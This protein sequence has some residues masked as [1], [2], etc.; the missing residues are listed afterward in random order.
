[1]D[2]SATEAAQCL[3]DTINNAFLFPLIALLSAV[4]FVVFLYGAFEYVRNSASQEGRQT[5]QRHLLYGVIGLLVMFSA[6][7]LLQIAAGTFGLSAENRTVMCGEGTGSIGPGTAE[8]SSG[9]GS[10][11]TETSID[12]AP[13]INPQPGDAPGRPAPPSGP[14][15]GGQNGLPTVDTS[16]PSTV[17][18]TYNTLDNPTNCGADRVCIEDTWESDCISRPGT[19][20]FRYDENEESFQCIQAA[21]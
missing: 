18:E 1:M 12:R 20:M 19:T 21:Q 9:F 2:R 5:G 7:T 4:A 13:G 14:V 6:F 17:V 16:A 8:P 10:A 3:V 11:P 15:P